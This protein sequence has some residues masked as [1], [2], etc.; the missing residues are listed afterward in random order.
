[1][2]EWWRRWLYPIR[3]LIPRNRRDAEED[4]EA[5]VGTHLEI[6]ARENLE[7]GMSPSAR[8]TLPP[9]VPLATWVSTRRILGSRGVWAR[10]IGSGKTFATG[11]GCSPR[12]AW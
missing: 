5:E 12:S 6:E 3:L 4:L 2:S 11:L 9:A 10:W 8:P 7:A 1:M